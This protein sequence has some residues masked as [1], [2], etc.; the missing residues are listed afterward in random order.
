MDYGELLIA[1]G[2]LYMKTAHTLKKS[3]SHSASHLQAG[4]ST[5]RSKT[6]HGLPKMPHSLGM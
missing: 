5:G 4:K 1:T 3:V 2:R 6:E